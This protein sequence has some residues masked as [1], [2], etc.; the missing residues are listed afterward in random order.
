MNLWYYDIFLGSITMTRGKTP[1]SMTLPDVVVYVVS[2]YHVFYALASGI[3][4]LLRV[5]FWTD[6]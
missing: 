2:S 4:L 3:H 1:K 6:S 5:L